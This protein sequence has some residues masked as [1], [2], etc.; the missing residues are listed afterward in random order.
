MEFPGFEQADFDLFG[1]PGFAARM[2]EIRSRLRP[3]LIALGE[4]LRAD[5]A[6]ITGDEI[7]A[8][9]A[10]HM[11]RTINPPPETWAAFGRSA[12]GY[13][14]YVH[15]RAAVSE[16]GVR[17]TVFVEDDADDKPILA[18][19]LRADTPGLLARIGDGSRVLWYTAPVPEGAPP[20]GGDRATA[21]VVREIGETLATRKLAKFQAGIALGR[22]AA[23]VGHPQRFR[24]AALQA[25]RELAP[26]YRAASPA[27]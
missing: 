7:F 14:R 23:L 15:Y 16:E 19:A 11:R 4:A 17:V 22:D 21:A 25:M 2:G 26:I 8:H 1:I 3:K 27:K 18:E 10:A 6:A 12:R 13:K 20:L 9:A 24:D 5:V